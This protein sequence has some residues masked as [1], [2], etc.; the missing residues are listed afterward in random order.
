MLDRD[1]RETILR[2]HAQGHGKKTIART[3]GVSRNAVRRVLQQ[4]QVEVPRLERAEQLE[5]HLDR[6]REL[7][8]AVQ[9]NLVRVHEELEA[10]GVRVPYPT[11]TAFCRRHGIGVRVQQRVGVPRSRCPAH[12]WE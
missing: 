6:I 4:G 10:E 7:H 12:R 5:P 2:L 9:G 11:L 1:T 8:A 3:L